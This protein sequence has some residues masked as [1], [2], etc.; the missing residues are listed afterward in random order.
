VRRSVT[1][2]FLAMLVSF[3]AACGGS[4]TTTPST[5]T[6][7]T[8]ESFAGD[9]HLGTVNTHTFKITS[10]GVVTA[11]LVTLTPLST[12][13]IGMTLGVYDGTNCTIVADTN[14]MRVATTL[15]GTATQDGLTLC[16]KVY[17][18]GNIM[19][20]TTWSYTASVVHY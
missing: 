10:K 1:A 15:T 5:T 13:A 16:L 18:S 14:N 2:V 4:T 20:D 9:L 12:A 11:S 6:V 17:D 3:L 7:T 8:T 19:A